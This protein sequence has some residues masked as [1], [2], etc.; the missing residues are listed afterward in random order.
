MC[1]EPACAQVPHVQ[2]MPQ[3][4]MIW[5]SALYPNSLVLE[6]Q[7]IS[8]KQWHFVFLFTLLL[9]DCDRP[10]SGRSSHEIHPLVGLTTYSLITICI[11]RK[12]LPDKFLP[13]DWVPAG[14]KLPLWSR[15][16]Y[17]RTLSVWVEYL[18]IELPVAVGA[19]FLLIFVRFDYLLPESCELPV[20]VGNTFLID[21]S[22]CT[23][24]WVRTARV[25]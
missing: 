6:A 1:W 10:V 8:Q 21:R 9:T 20:S 7:E 23:V 13:L 3:P 15:R 24:Y 2:P 14:W 19:V 4:S 18:L 17:Q 16:N 12:R 25:G 11:R 22:G 5:L